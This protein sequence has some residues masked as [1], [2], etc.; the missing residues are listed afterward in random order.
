M[1]PRLG[2]AFLLSASQPAST[3]AGQD[4]IDTLPIGGADDVLSHGEEAWI[5]GTSTPA[6]DGA[7]SAAPSLSFSCMSAINMHRMTHATRSSG[8]TGRR[9]AAAFACQIA[10]AGEGFSGRFWDCTWP[11][12][13]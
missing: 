1:I 12:K 5:I 3:P 2:E 13:V 4:P 6:F 8:R 9:P 7:D 10:H 11:R